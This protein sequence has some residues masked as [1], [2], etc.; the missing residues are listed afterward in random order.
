MTDKVQRLVGASTSPDIA[1]ALAARVHDPLWFL[2][3]Q[4]Q[5]GEFAAENGGTPVAVNVTT[6][7]VALETLHVGPTTRTIDP[8]CPLEAQIEPEADGGWNSRTL[9]YDARVD[10]GDVTFEIEG[11][12]G[13]ELDWHDFRHASGSA[14]F[15]A[16]EVT[17]TY[18]PAAL[19]FPGVPAARW[20]EIE[21]GAAYFDS[22]IDP[23]P[24]VL[25]MLLP[26]VFYL[27]HANWFL[28]PAPVRSGSLRRVDTVEVVDSFGVITEVPAA[29]ADG[30]ALFTLSKGEDPG[31]PSV[32]L[33]PNIAI[34]VV[35]CD[36]LEET[37]F[38]RDEASNLHWAH[39]R[40]FA[41][42]DGT[43]IET[44]TETM[45]P[46]TEPSQPGTY[47]RAISEAAR[48]FIPYIRESEEVPDTGPTTHLRRARTALSATPDALQYR[49]EI[50]AG[51]PIIDE[52][53]ID[54]PRGLRIRRLQRFVRGADGAP[55]FWTGRDR[56]PSPARQRPTLRFDYLDEV[57]G[58][59]DD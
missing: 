40:L 36:V 6:R 28:V 33:A 21:D 23:E 56:A 31:D 13:R 27:D 51:A 1:E 19:A 30:T 46:G 37:H 20:W 35:D 53:A 42:D 10:A 18:V 47:Y 26:E 4:W 12:D 29:K 14:L 17:E 32:F 49:G 55:H 59:A 57:K 15:E 43:V 16:P 8:A 38:L 25:S 52:E 9:G 34:Q 58:Q 45:G 41:A 24:N 50:V 7:T 54:A 3:R 5:A 48:A 2:A 11:Y 39:E 44:G 22:A